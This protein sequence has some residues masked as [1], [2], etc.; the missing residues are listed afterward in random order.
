MPISLVYQSLDDAF[1][2]SFTQ[3]LIP[4]VEIPDPDLIEQ[5]INKEANIYRPELS[6]PFYV[7]RFEQAQI[8]LRN[9]MVVPILDIKCNCFDIQAVL[10]VIIAYFV[11]HKLQDTIQC[12]CVFDY[13]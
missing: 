3:V 1:G 9:D 2:Y 4:L 6:F 5:L 10:S 7:D 12:I 11:D 8:A 13:I